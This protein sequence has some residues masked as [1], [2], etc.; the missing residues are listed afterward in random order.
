MAGGA[1][2]RLVP[3][4]HL[5]NMVAMY[6]STYDGLWHVGVDLGWIP[7]PALKN[8]TT[9]SASPG[10]SKLRPAELFSMQVPLCLECFTR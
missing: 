8:P 5:I 2:S 3:K 7:P 6:M 4:R 9:A 1:S 10:A